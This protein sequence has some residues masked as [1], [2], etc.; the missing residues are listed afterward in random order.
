MLN[1]RI[2][3]NYTFAILVGHFVDTCLELNSFFSH[4]FFIHLET[5]TVRVRERDL[6]GDWIHQ[7]LF[8][9][10]RIEGDLHN[11]ASTSRIQ[12]LR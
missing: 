5:K 9:L 3:V 8:E 4:N 2:K 6:V 11:W 1:Y 7:E 12:D 10:R